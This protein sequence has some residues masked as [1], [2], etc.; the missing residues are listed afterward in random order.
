MTTIIC[1]N[2]E[3][4]AVRF[5]NNGSTIMV[6]ALEDNEFWFTIG[7]GYETENGAKRAAVRVM[8][9]HGYTF[10]SQEKK[11]IKIR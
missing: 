6:F 8:A 3:R 10:D 4:K 11:N 7:E 1:N 2:S 5:F 9:K